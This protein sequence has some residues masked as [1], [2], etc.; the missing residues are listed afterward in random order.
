[1]GLV[2]RGA[3]RQLAVSALL[4]TNQSA[5]HG[6]VGP[7]GCCQ[8]Y[9]VLSS[10]CQTFWAP[11][12]LLLDSFRLLAVSICSVTSRRSIRSVASQRECPTLFFFP[13]RSNCRF[14]AF[15]YSH[16]RRLSIPCPSAPLPYLSP[17]SELRVRVSERGRGILTRA[18]ENVWR[19]G[20][21]AG[22]FVRGRLWRRWRE[23]GMRASGAPVVWVINLVKLL[24]GERGLERQ[25]DVR[26]CA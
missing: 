7:T 18:L 6:T 8:P 5:L 21:R 12:A 16:L 19:V 22:G 24:S 23:G 10:H 15:A 9:W 25:S 3:L 1:V 20:G 2:S 13:I 11:S 4:G 17:Q 14:F 26:A